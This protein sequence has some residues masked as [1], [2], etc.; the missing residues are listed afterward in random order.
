MTGALTWMVEQGWAGAIATVGLLG[1]AFTQ[2]PRPA[3]VPARRH[4]RERN[5]TK[6]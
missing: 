6:P 4:H 2:K 1:W 3:R 5:L